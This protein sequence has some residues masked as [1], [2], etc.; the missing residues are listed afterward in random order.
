MITDNSYKAFIFACY[1]VLQMLVPWCWSDRPVPDFW[2]EGEWVGKT[3]WQFGGTGGAQLPS[4]RFRF[5]RKKITAKQALG[6]ESTDT[7]STEN[8]SL[9]LVRRWFFLQRD[10]RL[11]RVNKDVNIWTPEN[12]RLIYH[13]SIVIILS[14]RKDSRRKQ[15]NQL[16]VQQFSYQTY[17]RLRDRD[18]IHVRRHAN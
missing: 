11:N 3:I 13:Y 14:M 8:I 15:S 5:Q 2:V 9:K 10:V 7:S 12:A 6:S 16:R 17:G 4:R 18:I 1:H